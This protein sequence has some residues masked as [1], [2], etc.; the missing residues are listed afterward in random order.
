MPIDLPLA[1]YRFQYETLDDLQL[2]EH[3]GVLWHSVFGKALR[4][5]VCVAKGTD[6]AACMFLHQCDY[7]HLFLGTRPPDSEIMRK[8]TTV[9]TPHVFRPL[10]EGATELQS[11]QRLETNVILP[12]EV[13]SKLPQ[14][15]RA[16]YGAGIGGLGKQRSRIRLHQVTQH[17]PEGAEK[18][19]LVNGQLVYALPPGQVRCAAAPATARIKLLTPY[20][21]SGKAD[22]GQGV[23]VGRFL[24]AIIRRVDLM[25]YFYSGHKLEADFQHLKAL[26][27]S[28]PVLG[29]A[30][31]RHSHERYSAASQQ[32]KDASGYTG[33]ITLDLRGHEELWPFLCIGQWLN[34][35][36]N[37]SMGFGR[38]AVEGL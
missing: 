15:I 25:Q 9:P 22:N 38:Y 20:K 17:T 8:Y 12:G 4:N 24:M 30:L 1:I 37:A 29:Q 19:L 3:P 2:P 32:I 36:K 31:R 16:L 21:P 27:E 28:V 6:C 14:L 23:D 7:T 33:Q 34:V 26:T 5:L 10:L 35:G 11:G 13:N 18:D